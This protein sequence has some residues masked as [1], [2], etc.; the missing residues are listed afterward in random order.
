MRHTIPLQIFAQPSETTCGPTCLQSIYDYYGDP[1]PLEQVIQEV[2]ILDGGGTFGVLLASHALAR[3]YRATIYSYNLTLFDPTWFAL[4]RPVLIER[5]E[6]Q[7][8]YKTD[9]KLQLATGA[10]LEFLERGGTVRLADLSEELILS[11]LRRDT[12]ILTGLSATY[13]YNLP[14]E[15]GPDYDDVR[16]EPAGHFVVICGYDAE[17][18]EALIADP[19]D[20]NPVSQD[21]IYPV[22]LERLVASILLGIVT[23]DA[24]LV[25]IEPPSGAPGD[26]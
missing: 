14:R 9:V 23:Y 3:G 1:L 8:R 2:P 10:Y 20:P 13:L 21:L 6:R 26:P 11:H 17:A 22:K 4:E 18:R 12:P 15:L 19:L 24:N 5:L 7:R 25:V 16:G